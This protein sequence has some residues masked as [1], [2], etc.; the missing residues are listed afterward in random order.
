MPRYKLDPLSP[1]LRLEP[2]ANLSEQSPRRFCCQ[3]LSGRTTLQ[4]LE[5]TCL[6]VFL[7]KQKQNKTRI[8]FEGEVSGV[9]MCMCA[10][11]PSTG[12]GRGVWEPHLCLRWEAPVPTPV[13][14]TRA[15]GSTSEDG[16]ES[17]FFFS[18]QVPI[19]LRTKNS[20]CSLAAVSLYK[21]IQP[22]VQEVC[23]S[24]TVFKRKGNRH[25]F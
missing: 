15:S 9:Q 19:L 12:G 10:H 25:C 23:S 16:M 17:V 2:H 7:G 20:I 4:L 8:G 1:Q 21:R 14:P 5:G 3:L 6:P 11:V 18:F 22:P 24:H 13:L